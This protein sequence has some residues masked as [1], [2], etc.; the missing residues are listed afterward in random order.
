MEWHAGYSLQQTVYTLMYVHHLEQLARNVMP[1]FYARA[2]DRARPLELVS[3]VLRAATSGLL[4]CCDLAWREMA[5]GRVHDVCIP[6]FVCCPVL[7][8][9]GASRTDRRL[10]VREMRRV[11][12]GGSSSENSAV[13]ARRRRQLV[14]ATYTGSVPS[15]ASTF[16]A[17]I[18]CRDLAVAKPAAGQN[19]ASEGKYISSC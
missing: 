12:L 13:K 19:F 4:K 8:D 16:S 18:V 7:T 2:C 6:C 3:V 9:L 14:I 1:L 10:A 5:M 11:A 15:L 17:Y